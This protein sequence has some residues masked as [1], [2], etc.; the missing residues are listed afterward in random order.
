MQKNKSDL[1][2]SS[3]QKFV[4]AILAFLQFTIILDFMIISPLGAILMP[5]LKITPSQFGVIVS[6]YAFSAGLAGFAAAGFA[7]RF[8]R[9]KLL[10][11]FYAGFILGTLLCGIAPNFHFLLM[12]RIVTGLFGGVIGS[13]VFAITTDLF[14]FQ[15]RGRVMGFIQ[16]AFAASQI[17]GLPVGL[18]LA[19]LWGW[20]AGFLMIVAIASIMGIIM[21]VKLK[22]IDAHLKLQTDRSPL[23]HLIHTLG[24]SKYWL[25][26]FATCLM[27][28]GGFM[29]MPF[30]SAFTVNNLGIEI[31]KLPLIYL[32]TGICTIFA[33]PLVGR[34]TDSFGKFR[35]FVFGAILTIVMVVIYTN[36]GV[37]PL[38]WV[39]A[40]NVFLYI[41]IF[42]RM[43][44]SQ[45]LISA[46]PEPASRGSFMAINSSLQQMAGGLASV[47]AGL[48]VT[49]APSG[50]IEHFNVLG[51]ILVGTVLITTAF[52]YQIHR[53]VPEPNK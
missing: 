42:S 9:K 20:H 43:I 37:T 5:A 41:G 14:S 11:F 8:D 17:L 27:S 33:G 51:Y 48:I 6:A 15:Q 46:I 39:I 29:L 25:A 38:P 21:I 16:T 10:I 45:A 52:I 3:Y 35:T 31:G 28:L 4:I 22:P 2:F 49:Q 13:I 7:D 53:R 50:M 19:N 24:T 26:F 47:T 12:A 30:G 40:V 32:I 34:M 18:Y 23:R 44:P 1:A 36:L